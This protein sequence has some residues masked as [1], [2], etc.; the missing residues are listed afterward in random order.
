MRGM[1]MKKISL[2]IIILVMSLLVIVACGKSENPTGSN[3]PDIIP[4]WTE[5]MDMPTARFYPTSFVFNNKIYVVGGETNLVPLDILEEYSPDT[6]SWT[7]KTPMPTSRSMTAAHVVNGKIYVIGGM[8]D[9]EG[10]VWPP[11]S[12]VEEYDAVTDTW[13]VKSDMPTARSALMSAVYNDK[14]YVIS[15]ITGPRT[16]NWSGEEYPKTDVVEVYDTATDTWS[17]LSPIPTARAFGC[18]GIID[19]KIYVVSG[20]LF[21]HGIKVE[22]YDIATDT[23]HS[24]A[25]LIS[26]RNSAC[27]TVV[28]GKLYVI[29]GSSV[30]AEQSLKTVFEYNPTS[31]S[32][33]QLPDIPVARLGFCAVEL[34]DKIYIIGGA[35]GPWTMSG[36]NFFKNVF[37]YDPQ[38]YLGE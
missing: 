25:N 35:D 3:E 4:G 27:A 26:S 14:I 13:A 20:E 36:Y 16:A 5:K 24:K 6:N 21:S 22:M 23:W 32:W 15:G 37:E 8:G 1:L 31:D 28:N 7:T 19:G 9:F 18:A 34:N 11:I 33:T 10:S 38:L 30:T 17:T 29:G 2:F 12:K